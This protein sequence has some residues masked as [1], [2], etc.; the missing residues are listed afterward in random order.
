VLQ[1]VAAARHIRIICGPIQVDGYAFCS[2]LNSLKELLQAQTELR[3]IILPVVYLIK[4]ATFR[5]G[6]GK[7]SSIPK[8]GSPLGE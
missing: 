4:G 1:E 7:L 6:H 2:G 3:N 5:F 8:F